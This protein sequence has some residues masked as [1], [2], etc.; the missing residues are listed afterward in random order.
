MAQE[1]F[2]GENLMIRQIEAL[3]NIASA[4][5]YLADAKKPYAPPLIPAPFVPAPFVPIVIP[6][7]PGATQTSDPLP[8]LPLTVSS[9]PF[10]EFS[11]PAV[12]APTPDSRL[13]D[14]II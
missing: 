11:L 14:E 5:N 1:K 10:D 13:K 6:T 7:M 9:A 12:V 2:A 4:L 8:V 3:E